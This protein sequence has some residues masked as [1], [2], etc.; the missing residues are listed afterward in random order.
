MVE[1]HGSRR[2]ILL[3]LNKAKEVFEGEEYKHLFI[4]RAVEGKEE[5][6]ELL[7]RVHYQQLMEEAQE[8]VEAY[9]Y[10]RKDD[11]ESEMSERTSLERKER[12][13]KVKSAREDLVERVE[14]WVQESRHIPTVEL[15]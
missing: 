5:I 14:G 12:T 4:S 13:G 3:F 15:I 1:N 8:L 6:E 11:A 10:E 9:L 2:R 7:K